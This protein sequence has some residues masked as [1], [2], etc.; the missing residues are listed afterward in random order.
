M[1]LS[2]IAIMNDIAHKAEYHSTRH[3][4]IAGNIANADTPGYRAKDIAGGSFE[5]LLQSSSGASALQVARTHP[6]H[7][8]PTTNLAGNFPV[9]PV[10]NTA[11]VTP[12]GNDVVLEEEVLKLQENAAEYEASTS[13]YRKMARLMTSA[14]GE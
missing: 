7:I 13:L 1:D 14:L 3:S 4:V 6:S 9:S 8:S 5:S 2:K 11:E 10:G 12:N